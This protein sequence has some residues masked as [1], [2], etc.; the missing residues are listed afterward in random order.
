MPQ[1]V[2]V[3][4]PLRHVPIEEDRERWRRPPNGVHA[5]RDRVDRIARKERTRNLG[6]THRDA[7][8]VI[9]AA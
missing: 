8:D 5:V 3:R 4:A 7:V 1:V 6:V 2:V 9:R